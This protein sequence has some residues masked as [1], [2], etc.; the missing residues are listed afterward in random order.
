MQWS[1]MKPGAIVYDR[2]MVHFG[3]GVVVGI[4]NADPLA[5]VFERGGPKR[6]RVKFAAHDDST[7]VQL[8][9]LRR[10]PNNRRM[11]E[12]QRIMAQRKAR[13]EARKEVEPL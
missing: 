7:D 9:V 10:T 8:R 6:V 5:M 11:K 12:L 13:Q 1:D 2:L 3:Q 4:V